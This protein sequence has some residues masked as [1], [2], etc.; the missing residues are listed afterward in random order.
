MIKN[1]VKK[2]NLQLFAEA[3]VMDPGVPT[4]AVDIEML[5]KQI[6]E[7]LEVEFVPKIA[8]AKKQGEELAKLTEA[9]R[10]TKEKSD[11]EAKIME[12]TEGES[13]RKLMDVTGGILKEKAL[14]QSFAGFLIGK[15]ADDTKANIDGFKAIFDK[16]VEVAVNAR[17]TSH[18]PAGGATGSVATDV[19]K[20]SDEEY[21]KQVFKKGDK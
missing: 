20:L 16:A 9:E 19:D 11:L 7:K 3:G 12:L 5:T 10:L 6:K 14:D 17:L 18:V 8:D 21:Y 2:I 13:K 4:A 15:D 1:R